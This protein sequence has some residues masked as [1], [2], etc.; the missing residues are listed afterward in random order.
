[1]T[2][3]AW[4]AFAFSVTYLTMAV[5]AWSLHRRIKAARRRLEDLQ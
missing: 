3:W 5:Y 2:D 4:V 1:M